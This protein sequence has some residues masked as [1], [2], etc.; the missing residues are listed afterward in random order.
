L[1]VGCIRKTLLVGEEKG[2]IV[3]DRL[4]VI[5]PLPKQ[6]AARAR[7][8]YLLATLDRFLASAPSPIFI[9]PIKSWLFLDDLSPAILLWPWS[10]FCVP[11]YPFSIVVGRSYVNA[12]FL[13]TNEPCPE[14]LITESPRSNPNRVEDK[15]P[16][17]QWYVQ[18]NHFHCFTEP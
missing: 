13:A 3:T 18:M 7:L 17:L 5:S 1:L 9:I 15:S 11:S 4:L 14:R 16:N 6:K 2:C 8:P 12:H 10:L